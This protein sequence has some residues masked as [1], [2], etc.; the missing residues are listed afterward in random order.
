M[1]VYDNHLIDKSFSIL[2]SSAISVRDI[3]KSEMRNDEGK[4]EVVKEM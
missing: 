2:E 1:L 4:Y 3:M